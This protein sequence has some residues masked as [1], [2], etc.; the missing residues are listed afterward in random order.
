V[1]VALVKLVKSHATILIMTT[2]TFDI[3]VTIVVMIASAK[4]MQR[5]RIQWLRENQFACVHRLIAPNRENDLK[6]MY[7]AHGDSS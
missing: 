7:L 3:A 4:S 6:H 5:Q 1:I 2:E